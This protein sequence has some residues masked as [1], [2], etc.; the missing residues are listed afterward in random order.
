MENVD[1]FDLDLPVEKVIRNRGWKIVIDSAWYSL[2]DSA[3]KP[4][5]SIERMFVWEERMRS[6]IGYAD[7]GDGRLYYEASGE[8]TPVLFIHG[9]FGDRRHWDDQFPV[10][11]ERHCA[12]RYDVRGF[13][14]SDMPIEGR[15]YSHH[16]D[17]AALMRNLG[18]EKAHVI[19]LSMGAGIAADFVLEHP[20]M[21]RSLVSVGPWITGYNSR[22]VEKVFDGVKAVAS[23]FQSKGT[24]AALEE[25]LTGMLGQSLGM[26]SSVEAR[27]REFGADYSFWHLCHDD[28]GERKGSSETTQIGMPAA[29]RIAGMRVPALIVTA[30]HDIPACIEIAELMEHKISG[31][32]KIVM[33]DTGHIINM[34]RPEEFNRIVL[35]FLAEAD[36]RMSKCG[37][38][39]VSRA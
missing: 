31:A 24:A 32:R 5:Q 10:F 17:A 7:V 38:V 26:N 25:F 35:N 29:E 6:E 15:P 28:P 33:P 3:E 34:E 30:D 37:A 1:R 22:T 4:R 20:E 36:G 19:G 11:A 13:G 18:I 9:N 14:K 12:I 39:S 2:P 8:G 27:L 16:E 21:S 23:A